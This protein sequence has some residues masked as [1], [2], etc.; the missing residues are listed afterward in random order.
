L[1]EHARESG[2]SPH[3]LQSPFLQHLGKT[4][5]AHYLRLRLAEADRRVAETD[6]PLQQV[7]LA[8]GFASQSA[9]A[10]AYGTSARSRRRAA[11]QGQ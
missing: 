7:A 10:R 2:V 6:E 9:F 8:T 4:L 1:S 3:S 5:Q 11:R